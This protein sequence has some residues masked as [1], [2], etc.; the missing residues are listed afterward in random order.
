[1]PAALRNGRILSAVYRVSAPAS[2]QRQG[3]ALRLMIDPKRRQ[4]AL[5]DAAAATA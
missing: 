4:T 1:V 5:A 3:L 2:G